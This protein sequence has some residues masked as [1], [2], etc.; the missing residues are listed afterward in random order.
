ML[1]EPRA[2]DPVDF[3]LFTGDPFHDFQAAKSKTGADVIRERSFINGCRRYSVLNRHAGAV[4]NND[5]I[6]GDTG[7]FLTRNDFA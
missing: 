5:F 4:E 7:Y 2:G 3:D 1:D 6:G